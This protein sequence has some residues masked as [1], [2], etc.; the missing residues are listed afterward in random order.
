MVSHN[1]QTSAG[2][3]RGVGGGGQP[4]GQKSDPTSKSWTNVLGGCKLTPLPGNHPDAC[5][6]LM[7]LVLS[8][9]N[10]YAAILIDRFVLLLSDAYCATFMQCNATF[11]SYW[12][13]HRLVMSN[14]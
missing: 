1:P 11:S 14:V 3:A 8:T 7:L 4:P 13:S 12:Y 6:L 2:F 5:S 9:D 10:N